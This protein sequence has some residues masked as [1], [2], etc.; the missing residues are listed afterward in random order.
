MSRCWKCCRAVHT[1]DRCI[2]V[3]GTASKHVFTHTLAHAHIAHTN[4]HALPHGAVICAHGC[5]WMHMPTHV[6]T[7][8]RTCCLL[9][10]LGRAL[11]IP[12][13]TICLDCAP[14]RAMHSP[15]LDQKAGLPHTE[16]WTRPVLL[17]SAVSCSCHFSGVEISWH[18]KQSPAPGKPSTAQ[19]VLCFLQYFFSF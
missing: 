3:P 17:G 10:C 16:P 19:W 12:V 13:V 18:V 9:V 14:E 8:T 7:R 11:R 4:M 1:A 6:L 5:T 15:V 2:R